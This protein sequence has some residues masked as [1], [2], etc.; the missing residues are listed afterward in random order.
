MRIVETSV[1]TSRVLS[2][3]LLWP[4]R[5]HRIV[6][7]VVIFQAGRAV[8]EDVQLQLGLDL[9]VMVTCENT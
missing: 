2:Q 7:G 4:R 9:I 8:V 6:F 5:N 1:I 3:L